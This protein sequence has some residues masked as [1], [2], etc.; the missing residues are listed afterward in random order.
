MPL[1]H[2]RQP[3]TRD[4]LSLHHYVLKSW[5][6]YYDKITRSG[7]DWNFW[8]SIEYNTPHVA[9]AQMLKYFP[10]AP[11]QPHRRRGMQKD[12]ISF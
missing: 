11:N 6:D 7:K 10:K 9:C 2:F 12:T 1:A 8:N 3:V 5:E 4:R